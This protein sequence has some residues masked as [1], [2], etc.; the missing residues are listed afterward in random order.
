MEKIFLWARSTAPC[1]HHAPFFLASPDLEFYF[2]GNYIRTHDLSLFD[3]H[4]RLIAM[5]H[6]QSFGS[7]VFAFKSVVASTRLTIKM[8]R[9]D[10]WDRIRS[11][12]GRCSSSGRSGLAF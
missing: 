1:V 9:D 4:L 3:S 12:L 5:R 10:A 7:S 6:T 8:T 2:G 11:H